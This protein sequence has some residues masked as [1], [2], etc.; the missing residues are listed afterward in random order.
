VLSLVQATVAIPMA[1]M[2]DLEAERKRIEKE[3]DQ[4]RS[5]VDRLEARLK[6]EA[7]LTRAPEAVVEKERQK[8]YTLSNK[9]EK[10]RHQNS[11]L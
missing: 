1:S 7:F 4:T 11:R 9:L 10:L 3:L 2:F 6:D 8:L 5:E